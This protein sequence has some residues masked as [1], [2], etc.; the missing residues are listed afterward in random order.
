MQ[1][2]LKYPICYTIAPNNSI[3]TAAYDNSCISQR[4]RNALL[5]LAAACLTASGHL[6][7]C[8]FSWLIGTSLQ[9]SRSYKNCIVVIFLR[10]LR[11]LL[12]ERVLYEVMLTGNK[13]YS[14][15]QLLDLLFAKQACL[16]SAFELKAYCLG[17]AGHGT[18]S[19]P[20]PVTANR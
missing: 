2:G 14:M 10:L 20:A 11:D 15:R 19:S 18:R 16:Q 9:R 17:F 5:T 8:A 7:R 6:F 4:Y 1:N 12:R 13:V 3:Y